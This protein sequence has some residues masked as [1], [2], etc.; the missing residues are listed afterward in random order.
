METLETLLFWMAEVVRGLPASLSDPRNLAVIFAILVL[1]I[2]YQITGSV[3]RLRKQIETLSSEMHAL[4]AILKTIE[5]VVGRIDE[6]RTA[7]DQQKKTIFNLPLRE[8]QD[9]TEWK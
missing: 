5:W 6:K 9:K 8:D 4:R 3:R 7:A 2:L 1:L